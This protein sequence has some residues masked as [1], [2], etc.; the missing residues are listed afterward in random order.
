MAHVSKHHTKEEWE[1][2]YSEHSRVCLQIPRNTISVHNLL[3]HSR[4]FVSFY[5]RWPSDRMGFIRRD[6]HRFVTL[7]TLR[8]SV[9]LVNRSPKVPGESLRLP[10]HHVKRLIQRLFFG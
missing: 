8:D 3:V 5:V 6:S 2:Y 9:L 1:G 10:F 4:E 7:K